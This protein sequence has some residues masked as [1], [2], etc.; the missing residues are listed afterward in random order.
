MIKTKGSC[1]YCGKEFTEVG[2]SKHLL[3]CKERKN[4]SQETDFFLIKVKAGPYWLFL[5]APITDELCDL[6][7]FLRDI[8]LECCGHMSRFNIDGGRY[9]SNS[10][11][12]EGDEENMKIPLKSVVG[13][14][15][16]FLHEYDFGSTT[17]L[18]LKIISKYSGPM[19]SNIKILA[20]NNEPE[21]F[22]ETCNKKAKN[23]C[24]LCFELI[25]NDKKC[26][27]KHQCIIE[28]EDDYMMMP[29]VNSPRT[30]VCGYTG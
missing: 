24:S 11:F 26:I 13:V 17:M 4:V 16:S 2:M 3:S 23:I 25:C 20:R 15:N 28:E 21:Y 14:G 6:D 1:I 12:L 9:F 30:G 18:Q 22:C 7:R 27:K 19:E 5:Q 29:L 8:W 10:E